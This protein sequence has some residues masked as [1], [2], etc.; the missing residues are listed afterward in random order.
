MS[1]IVDLEDRRREDGEPDR[2]AIELRAGALH[3]IA[4]E[5]EAALIAA[6]TPFYAR[7]GQIVRPIIEDVA[8]FKGRR[9]KVV[10]L[11]PVT[12]D[13]LRDHLSRVARWQRYSG[14]SKKPVEVDPP[15][16]VAKTILARDGDWTFPTL[17]G[18][19]TTPTLRRDGSILSQPGYDPVTGLLLIAPPPMPAIPERPRREDALAALAHLDGLLDE[20][21]FAND[22]SRS[23]AFSALMTPV[24]RGAM[25][26]A[27]L[28]AVTAP[29]VGSG[30]SFLI[31]VSSA[32]ATGE[33]A[34]VIA[35]GRSEEETEKRLSAELM[36]GQ[37]IISIDNLNGDLFGDFVCQAIERPVIKPRV[38][39]RSENRRIENTVT[40]FGNGCNIRLVGD[41]VRR[42][43]VCSLDANMERPELR[44]FRSDPVATV[45]SAR[46]A[47]I[48]AVLSI[49]RGYLAAGCPDPCAPLA[50]FGDWS[51]LVRSSLVW[52]GR[53]DPADTMEI[54]RADD[55]TLN[56]LRAVIFA[57]RTTIGPNKPV[58]TS[59]LRDMA[60]SSCDVDMNLNKAI[61]AVASSPGR[62]DIDTRKLGQWLSRNRGRIVDGLKIFGDKDAHT[63]QMQWWIATP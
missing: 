11:K 31:D 60:C 1:K 30:K 25:Q 6:G 14:R 23:V 18:I 32:I 39:G 51:R 44:R 26:V 45:L 61:I 53:A 7:A 35:A 3:E 34:P 9:T 17:T 5:A 63:K 4:T 47:Y 2:R 48:A 41:V 62:P 24:A 8:A 42:V 38:L 16:D 29:E 43:I 52:L 58:T 57:W 36:T 15:P 13:M 12:V 50:S 27:P 10:R 22:A 37:P 33:I 19:I 40:L 56:N 55:P 21:P 46:G 49:V 54:A 28:H 20:F 59:D